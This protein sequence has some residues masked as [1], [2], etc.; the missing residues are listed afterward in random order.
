MDYLNLIS[1]S[2][3]NAWK[4]KFIWLFG[5]FNASFNGGGGNQSTSHVNIDPHWIPL[6]IMGIITVVVILFLLNTW[7]EGALIHGI[8]KKEYNLSTRF[9]NC[10]RAG[11]HHF[12]RIFVI[13]IFMFFA[14]IATILAAAIFL[15]PAFLVNIGLGIL[16][17]ILV[18]PIFFIVIFMIVA[19][20]SWSLR[21]VVLYDRTWDK[22]ISSAWQLFRTNVGKTIGVAFSSFLTK[23]LFVIL[24]ILVLLVLAVPA[25]I[26]GVATLGLALIPLIALGV[27]ILILV[28][29]YLG[30]FGSWVWTL[31]FMQM[32]DYTPP[33]ES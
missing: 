23:T 26:I 1:K 13:K 25:I 20:E 12:L 30:T 6:I 7:A 29:A 27:I 11:F 10:S 32:T 33:A 18:V 31:G 8:K 2:L 24:T 4:Y 22:S 21:Y 16:L 14:V 15:V 28:S 5:C 17:A 19:V 3:Q 9:S